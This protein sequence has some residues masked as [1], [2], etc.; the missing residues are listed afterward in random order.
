MMVD[1]PHFTLK[2]CTLLISS[3]GLTLTVLGDHRGARH[4]RPAGRRLA[5]ATLAHVERGQTRTRDPL[6][7]ACSWGGLPV[8]PQTPPFPNV[9]DLLEGAKCKPHVLW[10]SDLC[11]WHEIESSPAKR[12]RPSEGSWS[13]WAQLLHFPP[14]YYG[15]GC[16]VVTDSNDA[17]SRMT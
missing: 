14:G 7:P 6:P 5:L 15:I 1:N 13:S 16:V 8:G 12:P 4:V 2:C 10:G 9:S 17:L 11:W 3:L